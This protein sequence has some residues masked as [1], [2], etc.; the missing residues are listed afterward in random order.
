MLFE[1]HGLSKK[2]GTIAAL[3]DVSFHVRS[4]EVL[5]LL[6]PNGAGKSTLFQC[7][8]GV[9]PA[10]SGTVRSGGTS[11]PVERR[12]SLLFFVPD[13][14][15]PWPAQPVAWALDFAIGFFEG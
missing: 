15:A 4:G 12:S 6:G 7:L 2:F 14:I 3:S 9:L 10:E 5:G 1:V 8:A 11:I 13:G